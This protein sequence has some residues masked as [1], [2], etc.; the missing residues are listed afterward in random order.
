MDLITKHQQDGWLALER[1][2]RIALQ[3][4]AP[5]RLAVSPTSCSPGITQ[6]KTAAVGPGRPLERRCGQPCARI[7]RGDFLTDADLGVLWTALW[8]WRFPSEWIAAK[9]FLNAR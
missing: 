6:R 1:L 3:N 5:V 2:L 9:P 4:T 7:R 8:G